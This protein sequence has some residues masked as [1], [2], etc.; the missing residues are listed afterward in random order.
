[1]K[2]VLMLHP[3]FS[4][5]SFWNY[6]DVCKLV[7]ARYPAAPLGLTTVAALLPKDWELKLVDLNVEKLKD[8]LIEWADLVFISGMLPQQ[9]NFN[10]LIKKVHKFGKKVVA[11]GPDPTSQPDMYSEADYLVLG[12]AESII[13]DF[14]NDIEL[15]DAKHIYGPCENRPDIKYTPIPRFDLL[16]L[17]AYVMVGIQFCRGCP[18]NCEFCDII[19]LYGRKVRSKTNKQIFDEL[20][21]LYKLGYR[22]HIDFVDDNFI[23][24]RKQA[25]ILLRELKEWLEERNHPFY[26]STEASIN[27]SDDEELMQLM[28]EVDFRYIFVGI[29]TPDPA[30]L[31]D[32]NKKQNIDRKLSEDLDK[33]YSYGMIVNAGFILGFDNESVHTAQLMID[34]IQTGNIPM[35]MIGLLYAL[36]NTQLTRRLIREGRLFSNDNTAHV[37]NENDVDQASSGLNFKTLR[38]REEILQDFIKIISTVYSNKNYFDR[39]LYL[40]KKLKIKYQYKPRLKDIIKLAKAFIKLSIKLTFNRNTFYYYWRN[41]FNI[42]F[43]NF[44]AIESVVNLAAMFLHFSKQRDFIVNLLS[45]RI[46]EKKELSVKDELVV[47]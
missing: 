25:K 10:K 44:K 33:I 46:K 18:F 30:L 17:D 14:V 34:A 35:A 28:Q 2:K 40:C 20:D 6:K 23:G 45:E 19:E 36:P 16:K 24:N 41:F 37:N 3:E 27:I 47:N 38:P 12:E 7:G 11:G 42:I 4:E 9:A 26:F 13:D 8:S 31:A 22:G 15:G 1:M 43:T 32:M 5:N 21:T 39:N 29:E